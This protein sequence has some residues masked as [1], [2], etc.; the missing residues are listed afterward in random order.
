[1]S[2]FINVKNLYPWQ[3]DAALALHFGV[4]VVCTVATGEGKSLAFLSPMLVAEDGKMAWIISPHN[5][6]MENQVFTLLAWT[7]MTAHGI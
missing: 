2:K 7:L 5:Q 1:L 6:L 4:D 3:R